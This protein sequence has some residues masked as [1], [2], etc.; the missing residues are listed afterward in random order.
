MPNL[1]IKVIDRE[2]R[3]VLVTRNKRKGVR[4]KAIQTS[5]TYV[6]K[7][8]NCWLVDKTCNIMKRPCILVK[9][10]LGTELDNLMFVRV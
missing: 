9:K 5:S 7:C 6:Y 3:L 1:K 8:L 4:L 10:E 2:K